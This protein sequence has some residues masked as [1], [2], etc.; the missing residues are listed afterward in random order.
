MTD[1]NL[2]KGCTFGDLALRGIQRYPERTAFVDQDRFIR[3]QD[4]HD[5][6]SKIIQFFKSLGLKKGDGLAL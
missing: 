5:A 2:Y 4:V 3:Y 6:V 1:T